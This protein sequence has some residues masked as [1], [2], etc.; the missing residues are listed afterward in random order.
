MTYQ[1]IAERLGQEEFLAQ[2]LHRDYVYVPSGV[3][4]PDVLISFDTLNDLIATHRLEVPRLRLS[5]DSEMLPQHRYAAPVTTRRH[6]VWQ[7]THPAELHRCLAEGASLVIDAIDELHEPVSDL[8]QH[9]ESWLHTHVQIN[10]YASWS[11]QE[12]FGTHWDDHDVIVVQVEGSKHWRLYG[13]TRIAPMHRDTAQPEPPPEQPIADLV[14][15]PG[16][17]LYLP[18]G[19]W[20]AVAADQGVRSLHLTCGLTPH[21]GADLIGWLSEMLR[22]S[23]QVRADLPLHAGPEAQVA[24]VELLREHLVAALEEPGLLERF[25]AARD[26]EDLG[27]LRPSLPHL[28]GVPADPKVCVRLT[29]GRARL[30]SAADDEGAVVVRFAAAGQEV[31]FDPAVEPLLRRLLGG[32]WVSLADLAATAELTVADAAAVA[33]E[34]VDAQAATVRGGRW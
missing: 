10:A 16:D 33:G 17:V 11:A 25:A 14:L 20:H 24:Y 26:A 29:T 28:D 6:T 3:T 21:T 13:P 34:L 8:A 27:R 32:G 23:E 7:R 4:E 19:W 12:G 15:E 1:L 18:R 30:T 2:S 22:D 5:A 31:D 9:L